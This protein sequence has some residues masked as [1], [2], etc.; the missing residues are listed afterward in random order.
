MVATGVLRQSRAGRAS[1]LGDL[2]GCVGVSAQE[3]GGGARF[4]MGG[5]R[6]SAVAEPRPSEVPLGE[7][8]C[9]EICDVLGLQQG[10]CGR[11]HLEVE[12]PYEKGRHCRSGDIVVGAEPVAAGWAT[13]D[14]DTG[15]GQPVDVVFENRVVDIV[16]AVIAAATGVPEGPRNAAICPRVT[17]S[18]GENR[19]LSG[20]LHRL[21]SPSPPGSR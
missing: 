12:S 11:C 17:G 9:S 4:V 5:D 8:E 14:G 10:E 13:S 18:S 15:I 1:D 21:V 7:R 16:E 2:F 6:S 3:E 20:G 19:S